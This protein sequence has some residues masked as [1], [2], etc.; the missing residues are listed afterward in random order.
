MRELH[1]L[2]E[3]VRCD[4]I[5][6]T[7]RPGTGGI[8]RQVNPTPGCP[9]CNPPGPCPTAARSHTAPQIPV[10][11]LLQ[12]V[13]QPPEPSHPVAFGAHHS[14]LRLVAQ[15]ALQGHPRSRRFLRRR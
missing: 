11:G 2:R 7:G 8:V 12:P 14:H 15:R 1:D 10:A 6:P 3:S 5:H 13:L 4:A 9:R